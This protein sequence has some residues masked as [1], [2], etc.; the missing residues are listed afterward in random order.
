MATTR[1]DRNQNFFKWEP[2]EEGNNRFTRNAP[3]NWFYE[4]IEAADLH[5]Q[6]EEKGTAPDIGTLMSQEDI[7]A[8]QDMASMTPTNAELLKA[9]ELFQPPPRWFEEDEERPF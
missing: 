6:E 2:V 3:P 1:R 5:L 8:E 4:I 9:A 7:L